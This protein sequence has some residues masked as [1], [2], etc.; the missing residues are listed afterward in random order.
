MVRWC[1]PGDNVAGDVDALVQIPLRSVISRI[2][3]V[4]AHCSGHVTLLP[5]LVIACRHG[6]VHGLVAGWR[7]EPSEV[8]EPAQR[9]AYLAAFTLQARTRQIDIGGLGS[10]WHDRLGLPRSAKSVL[11]R[12]RS[13]PP[14]A[15]HWRY[16]LSRRLL[17]K[18]H[19]LTEK[20]PRRW[21]VDPL[22]PRLAH[23]L[24]P[25]EA[26]PDSGYSDNHVRVAKKARSARITCADFGAVVHA[27]SKPR[28]RQGGEGLLGNPSRPS[29]TQ[30]GT[31][32]AATV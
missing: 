7:G 2:R 14:S 6:L 29:R 16:Q 9:D 32:S 13:V 1:S 3:P 21:R 31:R 28:G 26:Y 8:A 5:R 12:R 17:G 24:S 18:G 22:V 15:P 23:A 19:K 4:L 10:C 25:G 11:L 27:K 20:P 30:V